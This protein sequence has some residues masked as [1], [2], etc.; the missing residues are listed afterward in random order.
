MVTSLGS[1]IYNRQNWK[2]EDFPILCQMCFGENPYIQMTK[3]KYGKECKICASGAPGKSKNVY[4]TCLLDLEYEISNSDGMWPV[5][6]LGK[7]TST[8]DM[9]LKLAETTPTT[10]GI[11]C[12]FAP[13]GPYGINDPMTDKLLKQASRMPCLDPPE[14]KT[15]TTLYYHCIHCAFI[16]FA[17]R[18]AAE[19]AARK[20]F[21]KLVV[22]GSRG[23]EE[24]KDRTT[25]TGIKLEP[26]PGLP[27]ALPPPAAA[28]EAS[29]DYFN[30]PPSGPPAVVNH[31]PAIPTWYCPLPPPGFGPHMFHSMGPSPPFMRAPGP[32]HYPSQDPQRMGAHARKHSSP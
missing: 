7:A 21:N 2:V 8:S 22:N 17:T 1:S 30:L 14:G 31:C 27:G 25:D 28:E 16:Q 5:G 19:V 18:Q 3:E 24:E 23:K 20:S 9:L 11:D 29:A 15:I 12:T 26:V 10:K 4:Q 13:S 6:M 32:I